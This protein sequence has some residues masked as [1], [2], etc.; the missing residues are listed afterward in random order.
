MLCSNQWT[1]GARSRPEAVAASSPVLADSPDSAAYQALLRDKV[2]RAVMSE[3]PADFNE[4][5][6]SL[7]AE[8]GDIPEGPVS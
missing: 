2:R 6:E 1:A 7:Q 4:R 8:A 5:R 3:Y